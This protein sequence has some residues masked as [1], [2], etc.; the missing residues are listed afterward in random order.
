[1]LFLMFLNNPYDLLVY[2]VKYVSLIFLIDRFPELMTKIRS[3]R[4]LHQWPMTLNP[5]RH[6]Y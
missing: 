6:S 2:N 1:M 5:C 3:I 4:F